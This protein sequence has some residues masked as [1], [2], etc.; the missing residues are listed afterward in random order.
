MLHKTEYRGGGGAHL[1]LPGLEP[2]GGEPLMSVVWYSIASVAR[3]WR[4]RNLIITL[5]LHYSRV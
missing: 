4:Y 3:V 5:P 1:P 2:V